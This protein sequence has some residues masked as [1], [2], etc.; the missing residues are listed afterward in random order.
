MIIL[1]KIR[2]EKSGGNLAVETAKKRP[3]PPFFT[4]NYFLSY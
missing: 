2:A 3:L 4:R 1:I